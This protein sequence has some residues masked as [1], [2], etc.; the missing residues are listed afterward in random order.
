MTAKLSGSRVA[1][2]S[3]FSRD[4][5]PLGRIGLV[6]S[7]RAFGFACTVV[8]SAVLGWPVGAGAQVIVEF[9]TTGSGPA[10]IA[11][12]PDG[13]LWFTESLGDRIGRITTAGAITEYGAFTSA[14][15]L[16]GITAGPDGALW[17]TEYLAS[18]IGQITTAGVITEFLTPPATAFLRGLRSDR[19]ERYGLLRALATKSG[20]SR[21]QAP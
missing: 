8:A 18:R 17:F 11:V 6:A 5:T 9:P 7:A 15:D 16:Q 1:T 21:P 20:G 19:M 13:A 4:W 2:I 3:K 14:R 10:D 12:G